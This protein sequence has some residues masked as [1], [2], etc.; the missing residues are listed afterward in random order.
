MALDPSAGKPHEGGGPP[1]P[2]GQGPD[3][4]NVLPRAQARPGAA[5]RPPALS[6]QPNV[7]GLLKALRRRWLPATVVGLLL[8]AAFGATAW[9]LVPRPKDTVRTAIFLPYKPWAPLQ[10]PALPH[11]ITMHQ[12]NLVA[13]V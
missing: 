7:P 8:A 5:P 13:R 2:P 10:V 12:R 9:F 4:G 11:G 3:R 1:G 6:N